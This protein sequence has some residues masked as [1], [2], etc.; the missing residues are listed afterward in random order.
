LVRLRSFDA[1]QIA[2]AVASIFALLVCRPDIPFGWQL[3]LL[4]LGLGG[5][6]A[7][8]VSVVLARRARLSVV[9]RDAMIE[10]G[11]R[12]IRGAKREV[13]MFAGDMSWA[14]SHEDAI[15]FA[16]RS[17]KRVSIVFPHSRADRVQ[18]NA[19]LLH[20]A[21]A[22]LISLKRDTGLRAT[23]VDPDDPLDAV[24]YVATRRLRG[25]AT[26]ADPG[27]PGTAAKYEYVAGIF[28]LRKD[29]MLV[30]AAARLYR[31]ARDTGE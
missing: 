17:G 3:A 9:S 18:R 15:R 2:G 7:V 1:L 11:D 19:A 20:G 5:G 4:V 27:E 21:G 28:G 29:A 16:T 25:G 12:L 24:L 23:L 8:I 13:V 22:Q 26:A 30:Q 10:T 6:T 31:L 14:E